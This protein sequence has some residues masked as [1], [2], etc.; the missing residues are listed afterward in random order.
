MN[1]SDLLWWVFYFIDYLMKYGGCDLSAAVRQACGEINTVL[2]R[3][4]KAVVEV[5]TGKSEMYWC[6]TGPEEGNVSHL[7]DNQCNLL[8]MLDTK[9]T[10]KYVSTPDSLL[11]HGERGEA[12]EGFVAIMALA[13]IVGIAVYLFVWPFVTVAINFSNIINGIY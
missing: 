11:D 5:S 2:L 10:Y 6:N 7:S 13:I 12:L 9:R 8:H 1:Q 3:H 4:N